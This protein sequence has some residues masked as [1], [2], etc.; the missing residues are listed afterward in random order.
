MRKTA[1]ASIRSQPTRDAILEAARS[2]FLAH[3]YGQV[4]VREIAADAG[5]DGAL[6]NRYFGSK[7]GLFRAVIRDETDYRELYDVPIQQLGQRLADFVLQGRLATLRGA[8]LTVEPERMLL[9]IRSVGCAE[10]LPVLR[11]ALTAKLTAPLV[12]VLPGPFAEEKAALISSHLF[13]FILIHRLVGAACFLQA[14][15]AVMSRQ[16]ARS[17]Q[18]IIDHQQETQTP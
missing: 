16:L 10:A 15:P 8:P 4:G 1:H 18:S 12:S 14:D 5:V 2:A 13:G 7:L 9:F 3:G 6:I 17:L 11:E